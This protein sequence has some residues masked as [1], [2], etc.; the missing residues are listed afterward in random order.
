MQENKESTTTQI[1]FVILF[2]CLFLSTTFSWGAYEHLK[3]LD[4]KIKARDS[5]ILRMEQH[6]EHQD[7]IMYDHLD[8]WINKIYKQ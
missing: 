2:T 4:A 3:K 7:S 5:I 1:W 6:Q 8:K